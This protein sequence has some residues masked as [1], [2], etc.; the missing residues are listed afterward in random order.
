MAI[1]WTNIKKKKK[2]VG[3]RNQDIMTGSNLKKK[4]K[5]FEIITLT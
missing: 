1:T 2:K 4:K 3:L 5:N